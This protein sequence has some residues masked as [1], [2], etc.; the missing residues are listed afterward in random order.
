MTIEEKLYYTVEDLWEISHREPDKRFELVYG[1]LREMSPTSGIHSDIAA[2]LI[3]RVRI[4]AKQNKLGHVTSSEGGYRLKKN[5]DRKDLVRAPDLGFVSIDHLEKLP[6]TYIPLA[7]DFAVEVVSANDYASEIQEKVDDFLN[8]GTQ[9]VWV[10]YPRTKTVM[11]HTHDG[12]YRFTEND[13][14]DGGNVLP[15]FSLK[16]ADIFP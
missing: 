14:L 12:T 1:E 11:V 8:F 4:F 16:V 10:V 2:E 9:I 7:P 5:E 6:D 13:T 3:M 15:G